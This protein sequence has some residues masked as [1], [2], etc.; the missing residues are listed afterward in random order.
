MRSII[1]TIQQASW[2]SPDDTPILLQG[3]LDL[4]AV[5]GVPKTVDPPEPKPYPNNRPPLPV[6]DLEL[7]CGTMPLDSEFYIKR[8]PWDSRCVQEIENR[9]GLVRIKAPRQMG[10]TSLLVRIR[11][12][13]AALGYQTVTLD[14]LETD[15]QA[16]SDS[17][18]F[19]KRFC[20]LVSR[21]LD[22][23]PRKG[24]CCI[25]KN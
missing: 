9:A 25:N 21:K 10:K 22:I 19:L 23:S 15:E 18:I 17:S 24:R 3:I 5:E 13:A 7:P 20:A 1:Q 4:I 6:A 8:E 14:F 2:N 12:R 11:D 16:F